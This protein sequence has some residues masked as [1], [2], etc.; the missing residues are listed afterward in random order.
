MELGGFRHRRDGTMG[1]LV[2]PELEARGVTHFFGLKD[3]ARALRQ[4]DRRINGWPIATARQVHGDRILAVE[5][6][7]NGESLMP[8]EV[9]ALTTSV[10][11][12]FVGVFTADCLPILLADPARNAVAAVHAGWR[13]TVLEI[14]SKTVAEMIRRWRSR[15][16]DILAILGPAIGACC[17]EVG[18]LVLGPMEEKYGALDGLVTH[19]K[20]AKGFLNLPALNRRQ[21]LG[22]GLRPDNVF[23]PG[24]C[25][26]CHPEWF[27]S[28]RRERK[29]YPGMI[30]G[31]RPAG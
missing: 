15:P 2:V 23:S 4:G 16:E 8:P 26:S 24:A 9:D 25:T 30:S 1:Y 14:A 28:Y 13:G 20:G 12:L 21:L 7:A 6:E 11:G 5:G 18:D 10:P 19:R 17:Y 31:I 3:S 29:G 22:Q 27:S